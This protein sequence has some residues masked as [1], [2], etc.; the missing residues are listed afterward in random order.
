MK[1]KAAT[2]RASILRNPP[3]IAIAA[4]AAATLAGSNP[5]RTGFT[6]VRFG[7]LAYLIPF[8]FIASPGL[9]LKGGTTA[10]ATAVIAAVAGGILSRL[11]FGEM[12]AFVVPDYQVVSYLEVPA[13]AL[14]G[15]VSAVAAIIFMRAVIF[16]EDTVR[17][18]PIPPWARPAA[19]G[20]LVGAIAIAFPEVL[21]VGYEATDNALSE[22]YALWLLIALVVVKT[23]ATAISLGCGFGGG[24]FSPS[25]FIGAMIGGAY[26]VIATSAFPHLSSGHGAYTLIGMSAVAGAV[27]G[28]PISTILMIFELTS[29]YAL[30][31][32]AMAATAIASVITQQVFGRS[33]FT[34][35][36]ERRKIT[37]KGGQMVSFLQ[38]IKVSS[39]MD[40]TFE[41][42][43]PDA[44]ITKVRARLQ[45]APWGELFVV[46]GEGRLVG[47]ITFADLHEYAFDT[48]HDAEWTATNV[49]RRKPTVLESHDNLESA[50]KTFTLSGEVNLPVVED[51]KSM[52]L[53]GVAQEHEIVLAYHRAR[54]RA[55]GEERGGD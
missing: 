11:W 36:L 44:P 17:R 1:R 9:L 33:F 32:G 2:S 27:L 30:T 12:A 22:T 31:I 4:F 41:T 21:G 13:F 15:V 19:G 20:L 28:A 18:T 40:A 45:E 48:S 35:Q 6:A 16:T 8:L 3:P 14:L 50:V 46:D 38:A 24:V 25:L 5:M 51:R 10:I 49:M 42:I 52:L 29:N 37:V 26:G 34:W 43:A 7:W 39:V 55:R 23:A 54:D 53:C 47:T